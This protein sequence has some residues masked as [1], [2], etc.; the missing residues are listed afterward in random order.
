MAKKPASIEAA[1]RKAIKGSG[2]THYAIGKAADVAPSVIDRFILPAEDPR[3]RGIT[4]ATAAR[5][6]A[7]LG[8]ELRPA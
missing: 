6:A 8:L 3:H 2:L 7:A 5:I 4:L 1:L